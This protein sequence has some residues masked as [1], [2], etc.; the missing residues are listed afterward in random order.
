M[1]ERPPEDHSIEEKPREPS[2]DKN[3]EQ[4]DAAKPLPQGGLCRMPH[5]ELHLCA[6][7][8]AAAGITA[9][10]FQH[11]SA[12]DRATCSSHHTTLYSTQPHVISC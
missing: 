9:L 1:L 10:S 4:Q 8:R 6:F 12:L 5:K 7:S 3:Q 2:R 11:H